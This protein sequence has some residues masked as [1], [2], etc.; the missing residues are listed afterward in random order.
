MTTQSTV[1]SADDFIASPPAAEQATVPR[2]RRVFDTA[3]RHAMLIVLVVVLVTAAITY[4]NFLSIENVKL[5][6]LQY[7]N[8]GLLAV[9]LTFLIMTGAFD[10]SVVPV[11]VAGAT[12]FCRL[13]GHTPW[14]VA[15]LVAVAVGLLAGAVNAFVVIRLRVNSFMATLAT[16]SVFSGIVQS[17][18][19]T[20]TF[21]VN[22][23]SA[24]VIGTGSIIGIPVPVVILLVTLIVGQFV[25]AN[26][27]YGRSLTAVG[28]NQEAARLAGMRV[29]WL[30][31]S[32][33]ALVGI[34]AACSGFIYGATVGIAQSSILTDQANLVLIAIA[35]VVVGGT[36]LFGGEGAM[37]RTAVG[38]VIFA[39]LSNVFIGLNTAATTEAIVQGLVVIAAVAADSYSRRRN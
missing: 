14:P 18:L 10:L 33:F 3:V 29:G 38:I 22:S 39:T 4:N 19:G 8:V 25:L 21:T 37:W 24:R 28:G 1:P 12:V 5:L 2:A 32:A 23:N 20:N 9:G 27:A 13:A 17:Y 31:F 26:T 6:L 36:S 16:A 34:A 15:L 30:R 11:F 35:I 7:A